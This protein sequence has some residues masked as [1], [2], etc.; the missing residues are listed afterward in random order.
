MFMPL[1]ITAGGSRTAQ[2]HR[3]A[4]RCRGPVLLLS[5]FRTKGLAGFSEHREVVERLTWLFALSSND[6]HVHAVEPAGSQ[7]PLPQESGSSGFPLT[8]NSPSSA[9]LPLKALAAAG[10]LWELLTRPHGR[11]R[12][13]RAGGA[14]NQRGGAASRSRGLCRDPGPVPGSSQRLGS[15]ASASVFSRDFYSRFPA[16]KRRQHL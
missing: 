6:C 4:G 11:C 9:V 12:C 2:Q 14:R 5:A 15:A 16:P 10:Q 3:P 8:F 13:R 1:P 7:A